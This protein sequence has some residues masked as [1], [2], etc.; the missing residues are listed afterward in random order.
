MFCYIIIVNFFVFPLFQFS[1]YLLFN[2]SISSI[3]S[4]DQKKTAQEMTKYYN[5]YNSF[6][7]EN[8]TEFQVFVLMLYVGDF[9]RFLVT[10]THTFRH[11]YTQTLSLFNNIEGNVLWLYIACKSLA[12]F[13]FT[14]TQVTACLQ[15]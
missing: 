13:F 15:C 14:N 2:K 8:F 3:E 5:T 9:S 7:L 1:H 4:S 10:Y 11:K 6:K 12:Y